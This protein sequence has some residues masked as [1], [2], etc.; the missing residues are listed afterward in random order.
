MGA[1]LHGE[2]KAVLGD[3]AFWSEK[4]RKWLRGEVE[5]RVNRRGK[6]R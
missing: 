5:Y 6:P 3:R 2:E 4:D 1:P